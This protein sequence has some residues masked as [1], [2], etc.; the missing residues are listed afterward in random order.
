[1]TR[2]KTSKRITV[3]ALTLLL[4]ATFLTPT[5]FAAQYTENKV[6]IVIPRFAR[7]NIF[8]VDLTISSNGYADCYSRVSLTYSSDT[9]TLTM[10]LQK[11]NGSAWNKVNSWNT[12]GSGTVSLGK[13]C[14]VNSGTYRVKA[15]AQVYNSSGSLIETAT[16]YSITVNY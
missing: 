6:P 7:I 5:A 14:Y 13:G 10:E 16:A 3:L 1:M 11:Q 9:V 15:T 2:T 12:S 8:A 4:I